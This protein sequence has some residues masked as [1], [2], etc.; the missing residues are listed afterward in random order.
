[1]RSHWL[2]LV[3]LATV[4]ACRTTAPTP[5]VWTEPPQEAPPAAQLAT[6]FKLLPADM[7]KDVQ[8]ALRET[9]V[10]TGG[11]KFKDWLTQIDAVGARAATQPISGTR[12]EA[13]FHGRLSDF[14]VVPTCFAFASGGS[15]ETA[16]TAITDAASLCNGQRLLVAQ[17]TIR[18]A[19]LARIR[20][21]V[22]EAN[23]CAVNTL[24][25]EQAHAVVHDG[26]MTFLDGGHDKQSNPVATYVI[27]ALAQ[28][29]YLEAHYAEWPFDIKG[30]VEAVGTNHFDPASCEPGW[31]KK[32]LSTNTA[33]CN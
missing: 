22:V 20:S 13:L 15:T 32:F 5:L 1:M 8:A 10:V 2:H 27:G 25:H 11:V 18:T 26:E 9:E 14:K 23:A 21:E 7:Q 30:C 3:V 17:L 31:G 6:R 19:T 4:T 24:A 33:S 28:C 12:T 16:A 29:L